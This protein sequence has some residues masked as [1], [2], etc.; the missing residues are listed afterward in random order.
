MSKIENTGF[1]IKYK[2]DKLSFVLKYLFFETD[3]FCEFFENF[4]KSFNLETKNFLLKNEKNKSKNLI[5][6]EKKLYFP[7]FVEYLKN[8]EKFDL[9]K[10]LE[11]FLKPK[12]LILDLNLCIYFHIQNFKIKSEILGDILE[13]NNFDLKLFPL[14][15]NKKNNKFQILEI[16]NIKILEKINLKNFKIIISDYNKKNFEMDLK[17]IIDFFN[18]DTNLEFFF[19]KINYFIDNKKKIDKKL[20]NIKCDIELINFFIEK[21]SNLYEIFPKK[22][23]LNKNLDKLSKNLFPEFILVTNQIF[24]INKLSF[25]LND[26]NL[27]SLNFLNNLIKKSSEK[28]KKFLIN[29]EI[30]LSEKRYNEINLVDLKID[31]F[32]FE[33]KKN[34]FF[35][36]KFSELNFNFFEFWKNDL[37]NFF[38]NLV[39]ENFNLKIF[40]NMKKINLDKIFFN[41]NSSKKRINILL[42]LFF[43][44]YYQQQISKILDFFENEKKENFNFVKKIEKDENLKNEKILEKKNLFFFFVKEIEI[45]L[46]EFLLSLNFR[47]ENF[48]IKNKKI[49][50]PLIIINKIN[51]ENS[52]S[53]F[54]LKNLKIFEN[55]IE[56]LKID[57]N[58]PI[59]FIKIIFEF[60]NYIQKIIFEN[61]KKIFEKIQNENFLKKKQKNKKIQNEEKFK[62]FN[63]KKKEV[64]EEK[65]KKSGFKKISNFWE[66]FKNFNKIKKKKN[67]KKKKK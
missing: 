32:F 67:L 28:L 34:F 65:K 50:I 9:K 57:I 61:L 2:N 36:L 21:L 16:E 5:E 46:Y 14:P 53:I 59:Y 6:I 18:F 10:K 1:F 7:N 35:N 4:L 45:N 49:E 54:K 38:F 64:K 62:S 56:I 60:Q 3:R 8:S 42:K 52:N 23:K 17:I 27:L 47:F 48:E 24:V 12:K 66:I 30:S 58:L 13:I 19:Y 40:E 33:I 39:L 26:K 63:F 43:E 31:N 44:F 20:E 55:D 22:K 37:K 41:V 11:I 29:V 15:E 25:L 51:S